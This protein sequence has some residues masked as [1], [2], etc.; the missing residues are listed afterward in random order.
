MT[1]SKPVRLM[2][3][4]RLREDERVGAELAR[5]QQE[6]QRDV[7]SQFGIPAPPERRLFK[8]ERDLLAAALA[9]ARRVAS[10]E[11]RRRRLSVALWVALVVFSA[12]A[13][14]V[15]YHRCFGH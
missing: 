14:V 15:T 9:A 11:R 12:A 8:W 1:T 13:L 6:I 2:S 5:Q 10:R 3:E 7:H 4:L